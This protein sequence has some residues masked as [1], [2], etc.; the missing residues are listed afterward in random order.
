MIG[1]VAPAS[2]TQIAPISGNSSSTEIINSSHPF[3]IAPSDSPG[4]LLVNTVFDRKSFGG[5]KRAMWIALTAQNKSCF[6]DGSTAEPEYGSDLHAAWS[7]S[8]M[9]VISRLLNSLSR[10]IS[11][12]VLYYA[13]AKDIWTELEAR[14]GQSSRARLYQLQKELSDLVQGASDVVAYFTKIK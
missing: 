10:D 1:N 11:E 8:N 14:Y 6:I 7:R 2:E 12:S 9:M 5:W 13:T 4:A 3:F